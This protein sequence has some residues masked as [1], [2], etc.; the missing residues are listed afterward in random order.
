MIVFSSLFQVPDWAKVADI[1]IQL[2]VIR[3]EFWINIPNLRR[4][5][6]QYIQQ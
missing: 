2:L 4:S 1:V 6:T 3:Y 5:G